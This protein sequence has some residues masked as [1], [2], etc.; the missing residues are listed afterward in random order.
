MSGV[1]IN[2]YIIGVV[3]YDDQGNTIEYCLPANQNARGDHAHVTLQHHIRNMVANIGDGDNERT[4]GELLDFEHDV[5]TCI[6][7][8]LLTPPFQL[9]L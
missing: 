1:F 9:G 4:V 8:Y 5:S 6:I 7:L 3:V 2:R